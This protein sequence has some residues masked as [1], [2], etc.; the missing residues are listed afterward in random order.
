MKKVMALVLLGLVSCGGGGDDDGGGVDGGGGDGA[1]GGSDSA[2]PGV[3]SGPATQADCADFPVTI[4][5]GSTISVDTVGVVLC[6][7]DNAGFCRV[8]NNTYSEAC[9]GEQ[10]VFFSITSGGTP[11]RGIYLR[12]QAGWSV[13]DTTH[14]TVTPDY[15]VYGLPDATEITVGAAKAGVTYDIVFEFQGND[16]HFISV[17]PRT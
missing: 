14:G 2:G 6:D 5:G 15:A 4:P 13:V 10:E 17:G 9:G 3:D 8:D 1:G 16:V 12:D 11:D 7:P